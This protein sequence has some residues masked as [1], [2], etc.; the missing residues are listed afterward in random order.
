VWQL[1]P[2]KPRCLIFLIYS[3]YYLHF[4]PKLKPDIG[5]NSIFSW[6]KVISIQLKTL[7]VLKEAHEIQIREHSDRMLN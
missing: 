5:R 6:D 3:F 7:E 1:Q 4:V 2:V